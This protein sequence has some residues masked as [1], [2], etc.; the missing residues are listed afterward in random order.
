VPSKWVLLGHP[1]IR[2]SQGL[3]TITT[4]DLDIAN[5]VFQVHGVDADGNVVFCRQL[6]R[7]YVLTFFQKLPPCLPVRHR[8][9]GRANFRRSVTPYHRPTSSLTSNDTRTMRLAWA[10][11]TKGE[12][13]KEPVALAA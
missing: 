4:V 1:T 5:S 8:I 7:R 13:Y 10:I 2:R 6:K 9:I 11:L 3:Q 12:R